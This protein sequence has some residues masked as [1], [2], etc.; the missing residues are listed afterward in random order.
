MRWFS[1]GQVDILLVPP[2]DACASRDFTFRQ[3]LEFCSISVTFLGFAATSVKA[4]YPPGNVL[5]TPVRLCILWLSRP[6]VLLERMY[7]M[8]G[9]LLL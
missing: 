8:T 5:I 9:I 7:P 6:V 4:G 1:I 3:Y 2:S